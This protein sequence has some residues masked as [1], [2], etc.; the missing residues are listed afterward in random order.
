MVNDLDQVSVVIPVLNDQPA[1][2]VL[3]R[4]LTP[5][6]E[7]EIVVVDGGSNEGSIHERQQPVR[8][9]RTERGRA[10]QLSAGVASTQRPWLW[11]LHADSVVTGTVVEL[12]YLNDLV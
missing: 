5:F 3:L 6:Q 8:L 2:E 1:L 10:V 9:L 11:F 7:L 4:S 12:S